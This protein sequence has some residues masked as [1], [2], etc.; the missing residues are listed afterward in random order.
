MY[1][2][3]F[4]L[5]IITPTRIVFQD[6]A[7]SVSVP[8]VM[9][10]FQVLYN[11]APLLA[12]MEVG[13]LKVK[14]SHGKDMIYATSGGFVE[15]KENDVVVLAETV[16][17]AQEIDAQRAEAAQRRA[18]ERLQSHQATIDRA[19]AQAAL[20]RALNRLRVARKA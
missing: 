20:M 8:G 1:E 7:T 5:Q 18:A 4:K 9:G 11:H 3:A 15:V 16:E 13:E 19:R 17:P 14:D 6:E 2:H 12:A 10:G